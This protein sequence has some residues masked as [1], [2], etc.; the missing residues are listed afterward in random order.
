M[1]NIVDKILNL[2]LT[3]GNA[4]YIGENVSQIDHALQ[5]AS[6]AE[7]DKRLDLVDEYVKNCVIIASLLH[8]IGHLIYMENTAHTNINIIIN[9]INDVNVVND[10]H[11]NNINRLGNLGII[12]HDIIGRNY[13]KECGMPVLIYELVGSHVQAKR[14]LCTINRHYYDKL[15]NASKETM[16]MQG[17][18]MSLHELTEFNNSIMPELK[19]FLRE[20]DDL[21]KI[22]QNLNKMDT[23]MDTGMGILKYK[24]KIEKVLSL[25]RVFH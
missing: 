2:Y 13:L 4:N 8:D 10:N 11:N 15:S 6:H 23:G 17:G 14:Y 18:L 9:D 20:Y 12:D 7:N 5:T 19:V 22:Q 16:K 25:N 3:Y 24:Q 21:G 1:N